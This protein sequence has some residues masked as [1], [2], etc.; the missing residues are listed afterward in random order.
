MGDPLSF[1]ASII[2]VVQLSS[3]IIFYLRQVK[4]SGK[5]C[6]NLLLDIEYT[7][8]ILDILHDTIQDIGSSG[9]WGSTLKILESDKSPVGTLKVIL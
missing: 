8:G 1:T 7:R 2:A 6:R 3:A 9:E 4:N 5:E